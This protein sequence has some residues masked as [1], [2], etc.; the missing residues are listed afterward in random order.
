VDSEGKES[1]LHIFIK[2]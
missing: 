1:Y 2:N